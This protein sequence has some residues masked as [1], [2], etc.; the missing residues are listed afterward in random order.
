DHMFD[1]IPT[2]DYYSL[3]GIFASSYEP[4]NLPLIGPDPTHDPEY[5][6]YYVQRT[7]LQTQL[8]DV[9]GRFRR[10]DQ[11][12]RRELIRERIETQNKIDALELTHPGAPARANVLFDSSSPKDSPVFIR[13]EAENKGPIVPRQFLEC[14]SGPNRKPFNLGSGRIELAN[15]M[16]SKSNPLTARVMV[17][18]IWQ[19][20][21]GEGIV[22]TPDD[23][24]AMGAPPSHPELLDYLAGYFMDHGW[25]IKEMHRL[26]LRSKTY[27]QSSGANPRYAQID[28][29]NRLLWRQNLRRLEFE[30]LR[31]SFLAIGGQLD[32]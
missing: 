8:D 9:S 5:A 27:Q 4:K 31:D 12:T 24:G 18:R 3:R 14:I 25:A 16:A 6:D 29:F 7:N 19:H 17:N 2:K 13:G 28:P 22:A 23:F 32:T 11:Q 1:P 26:I 10:G 30:P 21:F 20:H 15:A